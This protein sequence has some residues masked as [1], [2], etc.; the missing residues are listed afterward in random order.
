MRQHDDC[1][2]TA[3]GGGPCLMCQS[4]GGVQMK[5]SGCI[6]ESVKDRD[7]R[8]ACAVTWQQQAADREEWAVSLAIQP[9]RQS[10]SAAHHPNHLGS[11]SA[12]TSGDLA[13]NETKSD[14]FYPSN[15]HS[16]RP[17]PQTRHAT[18]SL[19]TLEPTLATTFEFDVPSDKKSCCL[20]M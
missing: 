7:T 11:P 9:K 3:T 16:K 13:I 20:I 5:T 15:R 12:M 10:K 1:C 14:T 8:Q 4:L 2:K 19:R 18:T 6:G 17:L